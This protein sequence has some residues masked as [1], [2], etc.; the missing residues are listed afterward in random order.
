MK[1]YKLEVM[2]IDFDGLGG[3]DIKDVIEN[4]SYPNRC[5]MPQVMAIDSR[6]IDWSDDC[7]L[8]QTAYT[9]RAY[10]KIFSRP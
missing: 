3:D 10:R 1:V 7:A 8:N 5:I 2:V 6:D 4:A 9:D